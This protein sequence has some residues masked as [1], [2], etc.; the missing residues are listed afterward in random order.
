MRPAEARASAERMFGDMD[1]TRQFLR[2]STRRREGRMQRSERFAR[3]AQDARYAFRQM[4]RERGF[5][6]VAVLTLAIG[7]AANAIMLGVV[8]RLLLRPPAHVRDADRVFR[9]MVTRWMRGSGELAA[10]VSY[11]RFVEMRHAVRDV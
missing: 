11:R 4:R 8:D 10:E 6:I 7:I 2:A 9:V 1:R 5:T 3:I